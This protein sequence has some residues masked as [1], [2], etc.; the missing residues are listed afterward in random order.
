MLIVVK[1]K[2]QLALEYSYR[3]RDESPQTFVFWVNASNAAMFKESYRR[4]A[5]EVKLPGHDDAMAD[6]LNIVGEWLCNVPNA[7]WIMILDDANDSAFFDELGKGKIV[8]RAGKQPETTVSLG[9]FLPHNLNGSI[10]VTSR[11]IAVLWPFSKR[12]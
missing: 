6:I 1:R 11:T 3:T 7:R 9:N 5:E 4:I 10:L 8:T 2:S 12:Q